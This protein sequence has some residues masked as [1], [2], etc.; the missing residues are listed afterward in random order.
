MLT[1][2]FYKISSLRMILLADLFF[3]LERD[4]YCRGWLSL[5]MNFNYYPWNIQRLVEWLQ[6]ELKQHKNGAG[7]IFGLGLSA[8]EIQ[9]WVFLNSPHIS[10]E[11]L[12]A[13]AHYRRWS[14]GKTAEWLEIK[15]VHLEELMGQIVP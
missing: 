6:A 7:S 14:L 1:I 15:P 8:E 12:Q 11:Q 5:F 2:K 13:I 3:Y 10:L 4:I 9:G